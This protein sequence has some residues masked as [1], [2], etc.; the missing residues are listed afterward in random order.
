MRQFLFFYFIKKNT[1]PGSANVLQAG[2]F[3]SP[4]GRGDFFFREL[5]FFL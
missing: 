2:L 4:S 1:A 5:C 3:P